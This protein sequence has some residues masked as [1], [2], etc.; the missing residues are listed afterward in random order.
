MMA[1]IM[2]GALASAF[3]VVIPVLAVGLWIIGKKAMRRSDVYLEV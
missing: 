3:V 1:Y 2:G